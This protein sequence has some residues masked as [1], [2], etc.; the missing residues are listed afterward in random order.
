MKKEFTSPPLFKSYWIA[1]YESSCHINT[2]GERLDMLAA[3]QHDSQVDTDYAL[4]RAAGISTARDAVRWPLVEKTPGNY[5]FSSFVPMLEAAKRHGIQVIWDVCHYGWPDGLDLLSPEFV[6]RF[7]RFSA[8]LAKTVKDHSDE[9]PFYS[10][11]NE[12]SFFSWAA[13]E[14]GWFYPHLNHRGAEIK[15]QLVKAAIASMDA[16][17]EV[18]PRAR[19]VHVDPVI[20]VIPKRDQLQFTQ[21]AQDYTESQY[22][23]WDMIAGRQ[24][25]ELG[26]DPKYLDIIGV[27][28]Y[29]SNQWE[30]EGDRLRW[31][32]AP[33]DE[34][35]MSFSQMLAQIH[36]RYRTD[37]FVGET[38]H[39]G[40]GRARWIAEI[41]AEIAVARVNDIPI[42]GIC[43]YP[44]LDRSDWLD[45][46]HWHNSGLWDLHRNAD[47]KLVRVLHEEYAAALKRAQLLLASQDCD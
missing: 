2:K 26:G 8:A 40:A 9:L 37:I 43:I 30:Y 6:T 23:A 13:G 25:P 21:A 46:E 28:Y 22:E 47:G 5:D 32:D 44:I 4:L 39:F 20:R 18:D 31:E 3:T 10:P 17:R 29:H 19:F 41:A 27:N 36:H 1:G 42:A 14:S 15:R 16:I 12:I 34:R 24:A 11:I 7:A 33:R 45:P 35:W 38:S